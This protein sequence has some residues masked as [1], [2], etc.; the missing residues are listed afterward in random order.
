M[1]RLAHVP[2]GR[3]GRLWLKRRLATALRGRDQLERKLRVLVPE[4]ERC[5]LRVEARRRRWIEASREA[6]SW[7]T[8]ACLL[9]GQAAVDHARPSGAALATLG[10]VTTVGVAQPVEVHVDWPDVDRGRLTWDNAA[11]DPAAAA[12]RHA[13]HAGAEVA[14]AE[15]ALRRVATESAAI[16][17]RL[18]ALDERW[19]PWLTERLA[20][21]ESTLEQAEQEDSARLRRATEGRMAAP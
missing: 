12:F 3:A 6:D 4:V 5:R 11:V 7:L 1:A 13:L 15:E 9:S 21:V 17:R 16:R 8:R 2:P 20:A 19:L 10:W 18:R 14:V